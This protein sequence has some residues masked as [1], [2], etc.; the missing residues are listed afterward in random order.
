MPENFNDQVLRY[1][2]RLL[3]QHF[4]NNALIGGTGKKKVWAIYSLQNYNWNGKTWYKNANVSTF[5][6]ALYVLYPQQMLR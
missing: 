5:L 3:N 4:I 6:I 2:K 1:I